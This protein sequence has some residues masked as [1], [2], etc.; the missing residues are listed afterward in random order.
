[1]KIYKT[2]CWLCSTQF[3]LHNNDN[4]NLLNSVR[5][6]QTK[7]CPLGGRRWGEKDAEFWNRFKEY[8]VK[9]GQSK[10]RVRDRLS[11]T[12]RFYH[13]SEER[14]A[15]ILFGLSP[16]VKAHAMKSVAGLSKFLGMYDEWLELIKRHQL[17]WTKPGKCV[18]VFKSIFNNESEGK[19]FDSML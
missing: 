4:N 19:S 6:G 5:S 10:R 17:K 16:D 18:K 1:M 12:K 8:L 14:N 7:P 2:C 9:D 15:T 3:R 13:V 11:Y